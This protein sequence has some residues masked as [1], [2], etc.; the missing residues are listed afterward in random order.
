[1]TE[2]KPQENLQDEYVPFSEALALFEH[3]KNALLY[4]ARSGEIETVKNEAGDTLYNV[5]DTIAAG[6]RLARKNIRRK[7]LPKVEFGWIETLDDLFAVLKLDKEVYGEIPVGD[8]NLYLGW[9]EKNPRIA[10]AAYDAKDRRKVY[11]YVTLLPL[12]EEVIFDVLLDQRSELSIKPEEIDSPDKEG[13]IILLAESAVTAPNHQEIL[14][15][16]LKDLID[17]WKRDYPRRRIRRIYAQ[18]ATREGKM[19]LQKLF[20]GP[21]YILEDRKLKRVDKVYV[22]DMD[23][24]SASRLIR[25][26]QEDIQGR[27]DI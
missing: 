4:R 25:K 11:A 22:F 3:D 21:L 12:P 20:F 1:M 5:A 13:D 6:K 16:L 27:S 24:I 23:D 2:Q 15:M 14:G 26:F 9:I 17:L 8:L 10:R 7:K 19:I 18:G